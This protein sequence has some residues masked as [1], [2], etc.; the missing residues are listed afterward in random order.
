[1]NFI[2]ILY[3]LLGNSNSIVMEKFDTLTHCQEMGEYLKT[4]NSEWNLPLTR[5]KY[6]CKEIK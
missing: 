2:L 3:V 6:E 1:M 5:I 4:K